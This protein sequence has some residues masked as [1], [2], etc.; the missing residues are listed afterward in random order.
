[1]AN[2]SNPS[3][4]A[5]VYGDGPA[6]GRDPGTSTRP[7]DFQT[8]SLFPPRRAKPDVLRRIGDFFVFL[9]SADRTKIGTSGERQRYI[10]VGLLMLVTAAQAFYSATLFM[11]IGLGRPFRHVIGF[12]IFFAVAVYLIDR[13][14][15]GFA[16]K[17]QKDTEGKLAP[18]KKGSWVLFVRIM[19]AFAAATLMSEM[20][21]L[22]VFAKDIQQQIQAN[23]LNQIQQTNTQ[24]HNTYQKRIA[25]LQAPISQAQQSVNNRQATVNQDTA[26]VNCEEFGCGKIVAGFGRGYF[27]ARQNL[28]NAQQALQDAQG[29]LNKIEAANDP[30]ISGLEAQEQQAANAGAVV[31]TNANAVLSREE[32]FW[33]ITLKYGTVLVVRILL[34]VLILGID[35]APILTK[36]TGRATMHDEVDQSAYYTELKKDRARVKA[37]TERFEKQADL[38]GQ[39]HDI[40]IAT[41]LF[42]GQKRADIDRARS[43][44]DADVEIYKIEFDAAEKK[45]EHAESAQRRRAAPAEDP[46]QGGQEYVVGLRAMPSPPPKDDID[47]EKP[48]DNGTTHENPVVSIPDP[49]PGSSRP[50]LDPPVPLRR[51]PVFR[52]VDEFADL[53][54]HRDR[55][56]RRIVVLGGRWE[57]HGRFHQADEGGGGMVWQ[58]RD[59][60]GQPGWFVVKTTPSGSASM[61]TTA[62]LREIAIRNEQR[63]Q[64]IVSPNIGKIEDYGEDQGLSYIVYPL[65]QPGS[66]ARYCKEA[67]PQR[68]LRWCARVI[69]QVLE[70][71]VTAS[72]EG[73]VHLDIKPSNIVLDGTRARIID[74]GLSRA[75]TA[76]QP[77]TSLVRGTVFYACPEQLIRPSR[78]WDTP[79]ADLYS[80][81]ATFYWLLTNEPPLRYEAKERHDLLTYRNLLASGVRAQAVHE[82]VPEVPRA[83]SMLI[84]RWLSFYPSD[85][86]PPGT[87]TSQSLHTALGELQALLPR[88]PEANVGQITG[89][90]RRRRTWRWWRR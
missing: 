18:P 40:E 22:Q 44:A 82:L 43:R 19:V 41:A 48:Y 54:F 58:A 77:Y 84:D 4:L 73:L 32:A 86:V 45:R 25:A 75:W 61:R 51:P 69:S 79:L 26:A 21:L 12:G 3:D 36:I 14:I 49:V 63:A 31:I 2:S 34:T 55:T 76:N 72:N 7:L 33:Q 81:G 1:M 62:R 8:G 85:R 29:V 57:L 50:V 78:G 16:P 47:Q 65:Y 30:Q 5:Y 89:R 83:L 35:L 70:G 80:V 88:L 15:I 59:R 64:G 67:R 53:V 27:T 68:P 10:T 87:R 39:L 38:D 74:W 23:H 71:L 13:S 20:I 28:E 60:S 42:G 52:Q 56:G 46:G 90:R 9:T 37:D 11:S 66:L 17:I 24:I 6:N